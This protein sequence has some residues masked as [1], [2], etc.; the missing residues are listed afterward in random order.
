MRGE[1][2]IYEIPAQTTNT[3]LMPPSIGIKVGD[4]VNFLQQLPWIQAKAG[5]VYSW[6]KEANKP[7]YTAAEIIATTFDTPAQQSTVQAVLSSLN[8][9]I[10]TLTGGGEGAQSIEGQIAAAIEALDGVITGTPDAS[11]TLTVFTQSDGVVTATF[12]DIAITESQV[13]DLTTHLG[14]KAPTA[15]PTFT[16]TVTLPAITSSSADTAAATKKYVDDTVSGAT[17]GLSGAMHFKGKSTVDLSAAGNSAA[18]PAISGYDW[19]EKAAGDVVLNSVGEKEYVWDGTKWIELGD[20]ASFAV[21]GSITNTDI[22]TNANIDQ[23]KIANLTSDLASKQDALGF[24]TGTAYNK[25][26]NPVATQ[27]YVDNKASASDTTYSFAAGDNDGEIKIT[28][29]QGGNAG[30]PITVKPKNLH[31]IAT[32]GSIYDIEEGSNTTTTNS[33]QYLILDCGSASVLID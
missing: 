32:S 18:N 20:E 25:T 33:I 10:N 15:N 16:G 22:A 21:K 7:S 23:S 17:Q 8:N 9:K 31:Q 19:N 29:T 27:S 2:I 13:T 5:D 24:T 3:G 1:V 6:A 11:K 28:P 30:T 26:T 4:G 14:Q 12:G